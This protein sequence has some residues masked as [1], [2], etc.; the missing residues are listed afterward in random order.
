MNATAT[1]QITTSF[2][3]RREFGLAYGPMSNK[4]AKAFAKSAGKSA[5]TLV[6]EVR[7]EGTYV[8]FAPTSPQL[9]TVWMG[10]E[11]VKSVTV[12]LPKNA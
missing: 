1:R 6:V 10:V 4:S 2:E 9:A 3:D 7:G 5:T 8:G 11:N 12:L